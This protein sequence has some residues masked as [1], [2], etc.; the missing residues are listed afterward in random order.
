M[1][2]DLEQRPDESQEDYIARLKAKLP[3]EFISHINENMQGTLWRS[4]IAVENIEEQNNWEEQQL[5]Q[6]KER[7]DILHKLVQLGD[8]RSEEI[9][10]ANFLS[11]QF[12][13]E[14]LK[15]ELRQRWLTDEGKEFLNRIISGY[16]RNI[17]SW[18][19]P[20]KGQLPLDFA[21]ITFEGKKF[22]DFLYVRQTERRKYRDLRGVDLGRRPLPGID[23]EWVDLENSNLSRANLR[24][25]NLNKSSIK[26]ANLVGADL[27]NAHLQG[28]YLNMADLRE[29]CLGVA[30][31]KG[32]CLAGAN[33]AGPFVQVTDKGH[34]G[35]YERSA[36]FTSV[37][38]SCEWRG[39]LLVAFGVALVTFAIMLIPSVVISLIATMVHS[40][41]SRSLSL[42]FVPLWKRFCWLRWT[43]TRTYFATK[44][45]G[46]YRAWRCITY[47]LFSPFRIISKKGDPTIFWW[48]DTAFFASSRNPLLKRYIDDENYVEGFRAKNRFLYWLWARLSNCGRSVSLWAF[49]S[50][51]IAGIFGLAFAD[52]SYPEGM[53]QECWVEDLFCGINPEVTVDYTTETTPEGQQVLREKT[54]WT[55][56]YYS[57]VTFTTLGF[58]D[59][60]PKNLA[61]EIWLTA[62]VVLGYVFLGGLVAILASKL[63]RRA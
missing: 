58:G 50:L 19:H 28:A 49:W 27:E 3:I 18:S 17:R 61:A 59:V 37:K 30:N 34:L 26:K 25:A 41:R 47:A 7:H 63:A 15:L 6:W 52:Y 9:C 14:S 35:S 56:Y 62:E 23:L 38:Y 10:P 39:P 32:A 12:Y 42:K 46:S 13:E 60:K 48:I 55:P 57:I 31:I 8:R 54:G 43:K 29:A 4:D 33:I 44:H 45:P 40:I 20:E 53:P 22:C 51:V 2:D 24:F 1:P 16:Q 5:K 11:E 36:D 21:S